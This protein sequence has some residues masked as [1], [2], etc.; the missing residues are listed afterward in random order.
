MGLVRF[1]GVIKGTEHHDELR[2]PQVEAAQNCSLAGLSDWQDQTW[3]GLH[4]LVHVS[5]EARWLWVPTLAILE[6]RPVLGTPGG[7]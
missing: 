2:R 1:G 5:Y 4:R 3:R 6:G 7:T